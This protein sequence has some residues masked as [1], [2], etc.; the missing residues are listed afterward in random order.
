MLDEYLIIEPLGDKKLWNNGIL[1]LAAD[2]V[3]KIV[4][5]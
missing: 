4:N 3:G 5:D 1:R 2:C